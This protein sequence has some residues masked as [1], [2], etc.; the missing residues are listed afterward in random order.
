MTKVVTRAPA[1]TP[2]R[3]LWQKPNARHLWF[4]MAVPRRYQS[5]EPRKIIQQSLGTTDRREAS[6]RAARL[7]AECHDQ[8]ERRLGCSPEAEA[9]SPFA[10]TLHVPTEAELAAGATDAAYERVLP[11]LA[12]LVASKEL[13]NEAQYEAFLESLD[14]QRL[15]L[16]RTRESLPLWQTVA[17]R[18]VSRRGWHLPQGSA[19][20]QTL[21]GMIAEAGIEAM[22]V[23]REIHSGNLGTHPTSA[24][25]TTGL[26]VKQATAAAGETL[27][28][29]FDKYAAQRTAEKRKRPDTLVQDRKI[30][31]QLAEFVGQD[32][33]VRSLGRADIR[34]W[35]DAIAAVPSNYRNRKAYAGLPLR[36]VISKARRE[37]AKGVSLATLNKY[38]S[39]AS[40]LLR[41]AVTNGYAEV[42]P[43]DGLFY[44]A[45]K[46]KRP[47]PPFSS[48]QLNEILQSPLFVG[49][50]R[51]RREHLPGSKRADDWRVWIPLVCLF[52][53][54][55]IGEVAQLTIDDVLQE[56]GV[57]YLIIRDDE[58]IGQRTKS[59][60]TRPAAIHRKL[61]SIGFLAFVA[62]QRARAD[63]DGNGRLF[64]ELAPD[65]RGQMGGKPSRFWRRYLQKVGIKEG[66]DGLGAHSFR[67]LMADK[68]RQAG[69]LDN[70]IEVALGHNQKTV[71]SGYGQTKQ[72]TI[73]MLNNMM[74]HASFE[75]LDLNGL[76]NMDHK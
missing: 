8:W 65:A 54:S 21:L 15:R 25:V 72:G 1:R 3:Y 22:R 32:R 7:R 11:K 40:A 29:L 37:G 41:W 44:D 6:I 24:V 55:R 48:K 2:E 60:V 14:R 16:V 34:D 66:S 57:C 42:N 49:F 63:R 33:S 10:D 50:E 74:N 67:H 13:S 39:A 75:E 26:K 58:Q 43:C 27:L 28:E 18:L 71:T 12:A 70:Q 9:A 17:D 35:R 31:E 38:L 4:R 62:R 76:L 20:Y 59:G 64:P 51:D 45:P 19:S 30:I 61:L 47:R 52:S 69:Y 53:G 56:D 46:G 23:G 36:E 73:T 5:V 68:L